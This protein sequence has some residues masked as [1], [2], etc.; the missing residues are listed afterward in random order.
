MSRERARELVR[1]A[2]ARAERLQPNW[3]IT[4]AT[5]AAVAYA[6]EMVTEERAALEKARAALVEVL[7]VGKVDEGEGIWLG[8][9]GQ[10]VLENALSAIDSMA[11]GREG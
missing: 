9:S 11:L 3:L 7:R 5:D 6:E 2:F 4:I 8:H 10:I 1:A